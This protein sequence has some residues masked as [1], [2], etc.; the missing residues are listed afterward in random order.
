MKI[1]TIVG[2]RPQFIKAA[3]V[4]RQIQLNPDLEEVLVH[5]GQHY[6]KNLSDI[7]FQELEIPQPNYHLG[8]GS[9]SHGQQT[10]Q[11]LQAIEQVLLTEKPDW[12]L[13]YGDTNSTL[14]GALAA[15]KLHIPIAHVEAGLRSFNRQMPEE[16]N[17]ILTDH[18]ADLLFAPTATAVNHLHQEGIP[19]HK[20][21]QVGDVMYDAALYYGQKADRQVQILSQLPITPNHFLL[22]TIHRAENTDNPQRLTAIFEALIDSPSS[23]HPQIPSP[24]QPTR[25]S[26][27]SPHHPRSH[28]LF[29]HG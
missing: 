27:P 23:P 16:I 12:V 2:A 7:F 29:R 13:V 4:S 18:S 3:S 21:H 9:G 24:V 14:A 20:I 26:E 15:V 22:A 17:R 28:W 1:V 19:S 11:M 8:I 5:T 25:Q 10:G 6:D